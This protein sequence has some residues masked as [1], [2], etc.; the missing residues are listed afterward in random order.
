MGENCN[1]EG[2]GGRETFH[3]IN[4]HIFW[5]FNQECTF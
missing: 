1:L 4:F 5:A 3:Y 2:R